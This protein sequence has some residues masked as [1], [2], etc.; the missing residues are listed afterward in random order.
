MKYWSALLLVLVLTVPVLAREKV[1][2]NKAPITVLDTLE[3]R[4]TGALFSER[5]QGA[6]PY[7]QPEDLVTKKAI[8]PAEFEAIRN[9]I[10]VGETNK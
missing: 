4:G 5:I 1:N 7:Q 3:V 10:T 9:L 2:I 8:S 6:R